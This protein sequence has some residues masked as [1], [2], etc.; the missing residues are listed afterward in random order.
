[1]DDRALGDAALVGH[2]LVLRRDVELD[3]AIAVAAA[4]RLWTRI[5]WRRVEM[6]QA[7]WLRLAETLSNHDNQ[8]YTL[9]FGVDVLAE[10]PEVRLIR[11]AE[12]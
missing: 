10:G 11:K 1:M 2:P 6:T 4:Q 5:G 3:P 7:H 8:R 9:P 12:C